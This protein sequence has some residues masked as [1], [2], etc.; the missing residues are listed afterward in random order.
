M[1]ASLKNLTLQLHLNVTLL[2]KK[3]SMFYIWLDHKAKGKVQWKQK[4]RSSF[5][6]PFHSLFWGYS[7]FDHIF[8]ELVFNILPHICKTRYQ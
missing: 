2:G 3:L 5:S 6:C 7:I 8:P 1:R 4:E